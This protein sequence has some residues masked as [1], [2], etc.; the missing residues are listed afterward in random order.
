MVDN[1]YWKA[2][3]FKTTT[4]QIGPEV[5][6]EEGSG[7]YSI[8]LNG[9]ET[10]TATIVKNDISTKMLREYVREWYGGLLFTFKGEALCACVITK[11]PKEYQY[12]INIEAS[13]IRSVLNKRLLVPEMSDEDFARKLS[14]STIYYDRRTLGTIAQDVVKYVTTVK[15]GGRLPIRYPIAPESMPTSKDNER[16]YNG[17]S[18]TNLSCDYVLE[19]LSNVR[20]GPDIMFR[21]VKVEDQ[22]YFDMYHGTKANYRIAQKAV[23]FWDLTVEGQANSLELISNGEVMTDR[24][25]AIGGGMDTGTAIQVSTN[26]DRVQEGYPFLET[27]ISSGQQ[28][29]ASVLKSHA[30]AALQQNRTPQRELTFSVHAWDT[31]T[32]WELGNFFVGDLVKI[33]SKGFI[34]IPD[35]INEFRLLNIHG[36]FGSGMVNMALQEDSQWDY[37]SRFEESSL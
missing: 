29:N 13:G 6:I 36:F 24:V 32:P 1:P 20:N 11:Q 16:T 7:K 2:Y 22:L 15:P 12:T 25:F 18:V 8:S 3:L 10:M 23:P 28:E 14:T 37:L 31:D 19:K 34:N 21:P 5:S 9:T 30:E 35:G 26:Q 27:T 33:K 17:F 4:G